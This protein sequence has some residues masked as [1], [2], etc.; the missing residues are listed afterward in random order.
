[1]HFSHVHCQLKTFVASGCQKISICSKIGA[2][3]HATRTKWT[4]TFVIYEVWTHTTTERNPVHSPLS[5]M[6]SARKLASRAWEINDWTYTSKLSKNLAEAFTLASKSLRSLKQGEI[7][8]RYLTIEI[9][10]CRVLERRQELTCLSFQPTAEAILAPARPWASRRRCRARRAHT[11]A[12]RQPS[13]VE[14]AETNDND[15]FDLLT[16]GRQC[17]ELVLSMWRWF[18]WIVHLNKRYW[19]PFVFNCSIHTSVKL[20]T[21]E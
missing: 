8:T 17:S 15:T 16:L 19:V 18:V 20:M 7:K 21:C 1:V 3:K 4:S 5:L 14:T 12:W 10:H 13:T 2:R 9:V 6:I 11:A